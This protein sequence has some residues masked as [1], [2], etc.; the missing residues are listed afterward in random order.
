MKEWKR[1]KVRPFWN[2]PI[3]NFGNEI[4]LIVGRGFLANEKDSRRSYITEC[5]WG[6]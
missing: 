3:I 6:L 1:L 4:R 2:F 5:L